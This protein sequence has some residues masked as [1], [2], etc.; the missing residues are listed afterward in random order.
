[1]YI[2]DRESVTAS[3]KRWLEGRSSVP[4]QRR[5]DDFRFVEVRKQAGDSTPEFPKVLQFTAAKVQLW[6][7]PVCFHI[8]QRSRSSGPDIGFRTSHG[9]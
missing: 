8:H 1:V 3:L 5:P 7:F 6:M 2:E 4:T 9:M